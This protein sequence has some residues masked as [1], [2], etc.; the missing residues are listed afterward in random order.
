MDEVT[1]IILIGLG[2]VV[3]F[4]IIRTFRI[5][6]EYE[7]LV[8]L[9]LGR[10]AGTRGPG[11]TIVIPFLESAVRVDLRERFLDIPAQTAITQ[12]NAPIDIDF[13]IYYRVVDP[14]RAI[15]EISDVVSASL[16][17]ATTILR[18]VIGDIDLD[19]V[20]SQ[21]ERINTMLRN[22]LDE[23]TERWGLKITNVEI[24]EIKPPRD[25]QD[26][27]NRQMT[28]ERERRA[29]VTR[30]SGEREA[31]IAEAEG[32]KKAAI[33]RAEG[34]KES[35][36]LRAEGF[37]RSL[38]AIYA[39]ANS[40][41]SNTLLLQYLEALKV[42]GASPATKFV[43]PMELTSMMANFTNALG[44]NLGNNNNGGNQQP[45][46]KPAAPPARPTIPPSVNG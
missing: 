15:L 12:D 37:A 10:Y 6:P 22:K 29:V 24:R 42:I 17:M 23:I 19:S 25:V 9:A 8:I 18:A 5:V 4:A 7:R 3:L 1:T 35:Q 36:L 13:L 31:A 32:E 38:D 16:N 41:D 2:L 43:V 46:A 33:L 44:N 27:M 34:E 40:I 21:R 45:P 20:L 26:A 39:A 11:I 28:A 30:A 14:K